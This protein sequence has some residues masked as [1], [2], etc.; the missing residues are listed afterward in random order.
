MGET[1]TLLVVH[2]RSPLMPGR[3]EDGVSDR[4]YAGLPAEHVDESSKSSWYLFLLTVSIG[5]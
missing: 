4:D 2:E 1:N 5:G 3:R